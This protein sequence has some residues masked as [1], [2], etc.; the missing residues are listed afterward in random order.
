MPSRIRYVEFE[1]AIA[2]AARTCA[3]DG[4]GICCEGAL[5]VQSADGTKG[6]ASAKKFSSVQVSSS[7]SI[8]L[9]CGYRACFCSRARALLAQ[10]S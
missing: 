1:I 9:R 6:G 4:F 3:N 5:A 2:D 10:V 7:P 8:V